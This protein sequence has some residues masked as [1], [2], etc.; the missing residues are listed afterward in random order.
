M[1]VSEF[2]NDLGI[3]SYEIVNEQNSRRLKKPGLEVTTNNEKNIDIF[4][5]M[6]ITY[7]VYFNGR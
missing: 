6:N 7:Q 2:Q 5:M 4:S 3:Y 1:T